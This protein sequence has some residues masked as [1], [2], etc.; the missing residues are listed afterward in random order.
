MYVICMFGVRE[1]HLKKNLSLDERFIK[2]KSS[3]YFFKAV[4]QSM[5]PLILPG[6]TLIIDRSLKAES[7]KII[8][9]CLDGEFICKRILKFYN[10]VSLV[11]ENPDYKSIFITSEHDFTVFGIVTSVIREF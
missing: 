4:G 2:H 7:N 5:S 8:V 9:A 11:S 10:K 1:D 6:D 3:T